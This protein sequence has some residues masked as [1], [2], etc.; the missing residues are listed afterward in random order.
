MATHWHNFRFT[1]PPDPVVVNFEPLRMPP[2][3]ILM[4]RVYIAVGHRGTVGVAIVYGDVTVVPMSGE[5][6]YIGDQEARE[7]VFD[8]PFPGGQGWGAYNYNHGHYSH[9]VR[10]EA[11]LDDPP[12]PEDVLPPVVLIPTANPFVMVGGVLP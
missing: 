10:I 7:F 8:D 6:F 9:F 1:V 11:L 3:Q 4:L 5:D 2:G 12:S